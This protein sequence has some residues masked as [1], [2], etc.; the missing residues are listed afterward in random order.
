VISVLTPGDFTTVTAQLIGGSSTLTA[1]YNGTQDS[2]P[3]TVNAPTPDYVQIMD[4]PGGGGTDLSNPANYPNYPV[5][6][7]VTFH[8]A[9]FNI[10]A[11]FIGDVAAS[12]SWSSGNANLITVSSPGSTSTITCSDTKSGIAVISLFAPGHTTSTTVTILPPTIDIVKIRDSPNGEGNSVSSPTYDV[13]E[14][15]TFTAA[16][17]NLTAG[18]LE[19]VI[20]IWG[21]TDLTV[22]SIT[23]QNESVHL[24]T[25]G[26]GSCNIS[27]D[28]QGT[29]FVEVEITVEDITPPSAD[30]GSGATINEDTVH[31]FDASGSFD[32]SDI[33]IYHWD[34]GDGVTESK[35]VPTTTYE[36]EHPGTYMV[37]LTITDSGGNTARDVINIVVLDVTPPQSVINLPEYSQEKAPCL[38]DGGGSSD[39]VGI[40]SY[41]WVLGDGS[42][43]SGEYDTVSHIFE[44]PGTYTVNLTVEDAVGNQNTTTSS[45]KIKDLTPPS[46]PKGLEVKQVAEG[47]ALIL[48]WNLVSDPDLDHYDLY[49]IDSTGNES[50]IGNIIAGTTTYTHENLQNGQIY[51]YYLKA[52]DTSNNPSIKSLTVEGMPDVDS[53]SDG[54]YDMADYDDDDDGLSDEREGE[55]DTDPLDPDS[56]GDSHVDGEDEFPLNEK[57]W[58][59][60]DGDGYGDKNEDTFP[61]DAGE[62]KDSDEDGIGDNSDFLPKLPNLFFWLIIIMVIIVTIVGAGAIVRHNRKVALQSAAVSQAA[63]IRAPQA[64]TAPPAGAEAEPITFEAEEEESQA[65]PSAEPVKPKAEQ[66]KSQVPP[67]AEPAK[68]EGKPSEKGAPPT[69]KPA[70]PK[71]KV[72]KGKS[73]SAKKSLPPPPKKKK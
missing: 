51:R 13:G 16:G 22:C 45:V 72:P 66:D 17:Y 55:L 7:A 27:A 15:D 50:K 30:A 26:I 48:T 52:V 21:S 41:K 4:A 18:F 54:I 14:E 5:G 58:V 69:A 31:N 38:L 3:V 34:F 60:A 44:I 65:P 64:E 67:L 59:D 24:S 70:K 43:Y 2:V 6:H 53:D 35:S 29:I 36:Y 61:D 57:E 73:K 33:E 47:E 62:W 11:G 9:M 40:V 25:I 32:N 37:I 1:D 49:V 12:S 19:D 42:T 63:A 20:V 46:A 68:P 71:K 28:W 23:S 39:N 56:D 10:T 8:G